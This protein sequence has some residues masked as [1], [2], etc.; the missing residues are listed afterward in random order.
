[1][2]VQVQME[3]QITPTFCAGLS[4]PITSVVVGPALVVFIT[5]ARRPSPTVIRKHR[6]KERFVTHGTWKLHSTPGAT[7]QVVG[8]GERKCRSLRFG[9]YWG[10]GWQA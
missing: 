8:G 1:M 10:P 5:I 3:R 7:Q 4:L 6:Q 2:Q 9:F